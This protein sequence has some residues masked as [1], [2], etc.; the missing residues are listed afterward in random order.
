MDMWAEAMGQIF[1]SIGI[2]MGTMASYASFNS[3]NKPIIGDTILIN[4]ANCLLSFV[5][6]F[7]VFTVIGYLV[8]IGSPV[9]DKVQSI[10]LAFVSYPAAIEQMKGAN[11][12]AILFGITLFCL[13]ID[14]SFSTLE[15]TSTVIHDTQ[16]GREMPRKLAALLLVVVGM[17]CSSLFCFNWGFT[18]FDVV[19]H[20]L[21]VYLML[22][23]G[24]LE[25]LACG[26]VYESEAIMK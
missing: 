26:W 13:G 24:V 10:G 11:F 16:F 17:A 12:W 2:C 5:A 15:A 23:L 19:D 18:L 9:S 4:M 6:G 3:V 7:A 8:F 20:Y 25:C 1:F 14:S 21:N 22:F